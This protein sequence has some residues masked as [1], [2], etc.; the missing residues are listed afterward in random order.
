MARTRSAKKK[1][2]MSISARRP[3]SR[4]RPPFT[5][6][7]SARHSVSASASAAAATN[8]P[9]RSYC[10]HDRLRSRTP[11]DSVVCR[12]VRRL[13]AASP[14]EERPDGR[15]RRTSSTTRTFAGEADPGVPAQVRMAFAARSLAA[16]DE[17][18]QKPDPPGGA[19]LP[20][21]STISYYG[22]RRDSVC[23]ASLPGGA[24]WDR[25][26]RG[27]DDGGSSSG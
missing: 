12:W 13:S 27:G 15:G 20:P 14:G 24:A 6:V 21:T 3:A 1:H 11:A 22:T 17:D 10:V 5:G 16:G 19:R 4:S 7:A 18:V 8:K 25:F 9:R 26:I 2:S 23:R